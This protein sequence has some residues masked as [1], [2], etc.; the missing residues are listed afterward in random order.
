MET[1]K[2]LISKITQL[3]IKIKEQHPELV[4]HIGKTK[5][6]IPDEKIPKAKLKDLKTYYDALSLIVDKYNLEHPVDTIKEKEYT[7]HQ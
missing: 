1:K 4:E 7:W 6:A 2:E 5:D 3:K